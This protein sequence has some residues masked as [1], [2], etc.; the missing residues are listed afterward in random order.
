MSWK[1]FQKWISQTG[2]RL[3]RTTS[4]HAMLYLPGGYTVFLGPHNSPDGIKQ[5]KLKE[6]ADCLG[7]DKND[8]IDEIESC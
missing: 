5:S 3:E 8:L 1:Q 6:I 4:N 2:Y 7:I